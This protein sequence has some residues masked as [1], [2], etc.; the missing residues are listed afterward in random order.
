MMKPKFFVQFF[1][2]LFLSL[3][4]LDVLNFLVH[5]IFES[6][7]CYIFLSFNVIF[8]SEFIVVK[9][10]LFP[11]L[12]KFLINRVQILK[13]SWKWVFNKVRVKLNLTNFTFGKQFIFWKT[14]FCGFKHNFYV[15][16]CRGHEALSIIQEFDHLHLIR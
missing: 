9:L 3:S 7:F 5:F 12:Q 1:P 15:F 6:C 8:I 10:E 11:Y 14:T 13:L 4:I 16:S 2:K